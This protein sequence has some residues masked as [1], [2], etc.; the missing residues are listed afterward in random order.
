M[1]LSGLKEKNNLFHK[2]DV[3]FFLF[4]RSDKDL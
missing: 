1:I 4:T 3:P 2:T